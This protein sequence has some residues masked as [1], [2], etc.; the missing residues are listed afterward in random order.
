MCSAVDA[1]F[2]SAA[3][4]WNERLDLYLT[5]HRLSRRRRPSLAISAQSAR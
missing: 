5:G 2:V 3:E 1:Y 4:A